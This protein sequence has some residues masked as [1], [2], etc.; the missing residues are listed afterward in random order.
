M[1]RKINVSL[2]IHLVFL[3]VFFCKQ[4]T[5][6]PISPK[7]KLL[8][9][10]VVDQ[11][12]A[13]YIDRYWS[14][15]TA[16]GFKRLVNEGYLCSN[17]H[18]NYVPTYTGPGHAS[19][20][21]GTTPAVH[22][23]VSNTWYSRADKRFVYCAEDRNEKTIGSPSK[24]GMMSPRNLQS[25]TLADELRMASQMHSKS[26]GIALKDRGAILPAGHTANAA[27]WF[28]D[29]TGAWVSS[30]YYMPELPKWLQEF[31]KDSTALKYLKEDWKTLLPINQYSESIADDNSYETLFKGETKPV[32]PHKI[33]DLAKTNGNFAIL[34]TT[35]YGN[36]LTRELAI[37]AIRKEDLGK[38]DVTDF[39]S[40]S[41]SS[42]DYVGHAYGPLSVE[43]EDTYLR[44]DRDLEILL[45]TLDKE[46]GKGEYLLFLTADHGAMLNPSYL[47]ANKI[48]AGVENDS[49]MCDSL[50]KYCLKQYGD[51]LVITY[52]SQQVYLNHQALADRDL[53]LSDVKASISEYM[54]TM[55]G[56]ARVLD[57]QTLQPSEAG[58]LVNCVYKGLYL[59][60]SGDLAVVYNPGWVEFAKTGT[61]HGSG[62]DYDTHVPLLFFGAGIPHGDTSERVEIV[63]IAPTVAN[64]L[65]IS[66]P[67]GTSGKVIRALSK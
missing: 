40:I 39:L 38:D 50:K 59:A 5:A 60:R 1:K 11:M 4:S 13:D 47:M 33:A 10:I 44:L 63:D 55:K 34:R 46:V 66:T 28:D 37:E 7:P 16:G 65:G 29:L 20:F 53:S 57:T 56:V 54:L 2:L 24:A 31:N 62:Y 35:P 64:R 9:G 26:I 8:V 30:S 22:G 6:Q 48:S 25:T 27:Y 21:T 43:V 67:N 58:S 61:T 45:N 32:F 12:R 36:T 19:I 52:N 18:Y 49:L 51:S 14:K 42:T 3:L 41:F 17:T 15:W 23:I